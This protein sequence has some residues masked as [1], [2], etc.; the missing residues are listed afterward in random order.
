M[1]YAHF[2]ILSKQGHAQKSWYKNIG[3]ESG[4]PLSEIIGTYKSFHPDDRDLI[5]QFF[6]E[7]QKGNADKLSHKI[8][9]F[10]ESVH[11][12]MLISLSENMHPKIKS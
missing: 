11:G 9:V 1:G 3:E 7:V 2:N 5:L 6:E 10:R 8:R 12:R 4:T